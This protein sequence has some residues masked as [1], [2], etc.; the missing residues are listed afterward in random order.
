MADVTWGVVKDGKVVPVVPLPEG[1]LVQIQVIDGPMEMTPQ[2]REEFEAWNR[3]SDRAL[4]EFERR[5]EQEP[6]DEAR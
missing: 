5:L 6:R 4:E 3:L 2:E 1:Q